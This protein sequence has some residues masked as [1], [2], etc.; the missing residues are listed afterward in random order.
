MSHIVE[1]NEV[2]L[3]KLFLLRKGVLKQD[4]YLLDCLFTV[5]VFPHKG[6]NRI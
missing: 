1:K 2:T 3:I 4:E 5:T 6:A